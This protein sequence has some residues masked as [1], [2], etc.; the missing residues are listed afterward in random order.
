MAAAAASLVPPLSRLLDVVRETL[1]P[2]RCGGGR[3]DRSGRCHRKLG[4]ID[5]ESGELVRQCDRCGAEHRLRLHPEELMR[6]RALLQDG[7]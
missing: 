7:A 4:D 5:L 6:L 2:V 3:A 1:A